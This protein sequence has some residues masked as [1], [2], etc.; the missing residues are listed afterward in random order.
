MATSNGI[1]VE[2]VFFPPS[3]KPPGAANTLFLMGAGVRRLNIQGNI[4][5]VTAVGVYLEDKA[6]Q[7]LGVKWKGKTAKEL[8]DS[9][10]F[11]SDVVTGPF[12]KLTQITMLVPINGKHF[13]ETSSQL[14][15]E[16]WK[17]NGTYTDADAATVDKYLEVFKDEN[18]SPGDSILL[19]TSPVGSLTINFMKDGIV[20]EA[21]I[22]VLKN[23]KSALTTLEG[24]IG[25][26]GVSPEAKQSLATRFTN[27]VN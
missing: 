9:D 16:I 24:V 22:V 7:S 21:P 15:V 11:F 1:Q 23:E 6:I 8:M 4:V 3:V 2:S 25:K 5:K 14:W 27:S 10:E 19:A 26:N 18:F 12:E 13:S 17:E 20:S